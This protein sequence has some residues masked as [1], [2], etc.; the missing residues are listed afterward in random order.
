MIK[1]RV[2]AKEAK[3][4]VFIQEHVRRKLETRICAVQIIKWLYYFRVG[5]S[6]RVSEDSQLLR[7]Q[8]FY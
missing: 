1:D 7:F 8:V 6:E 5:E 4:S 2:L 3:G